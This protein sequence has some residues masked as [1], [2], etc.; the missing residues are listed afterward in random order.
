MSIKPSYLIA[1]A[2]SI[3]IVLWFAFGGRS[4][5]PAPQN[6]PEQ[7]QD[8][9][10]IPKVAV[11]HLF[12]QMHENFL[13]LHGQSEAIREVSLK[14]ETSG[15]VIKTPVK[16]GRYVKRGTLVCQ[17]EIDAR[18][19]QL[20]QAKANLRARELEYQAAQKLVDKGF[21]SPTQAAAA[22]AAYDSAKA[23]V[24]SAEIE[25]GNVNIRAPFSG[26]FERQIAQIGDYLSPGQPCGLLVD[27]DP[28][29]VAGDVTEKQVG[30]VKV[31]QG[32]SVTMAT[33]ETLDGKVRLVETKANPATRTFRMEIEI[34]NPA[35]KLKAGVTAN[36]KLSAGKAMAHFIPAKIQTLDDEGRVGVRYVDDAN[37]VHFSPITTIDED[38]D[39]VWVTGLPDE[40]DII[41]SGQDYVGEGTVVEVETLDAQSDNVPS[42]K[43]ED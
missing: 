16:E 24:K 41:V 35:R 27:L 37:T 6:E 32:V 30:L 36:I 19:A 20:E 31:G 17:Q 8:Q 14:A 29:I 42:A 5:K 22:L 11:S 12:A 15:L 13:V 23:V 2:I 40:V 39:G 7:I 33:G 18:A 34:P 21:R 3:V 25:L 1:I 28:L 10:D 4:E 26:I 9:A 38:E 43:E